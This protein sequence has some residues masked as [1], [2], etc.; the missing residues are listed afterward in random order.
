MRRKNTNHSNHSSDVSPYISPERATGGAY[1]ENQG[2]Q[3]KVIMI[4][5]KEYLSGSTHNSKSNTYREDE[6][7]VFQTNQDIKDIK[8]AVKDGKYSTLVPKREQPD[9]VRVEKATATEPV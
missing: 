5:R 8:R 1:G 3:G 9:V 7:T 6:R 2:V 4:V